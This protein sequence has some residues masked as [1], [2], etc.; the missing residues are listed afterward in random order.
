MDIYKQFLNSK[1]RGEKRLAILIDPDDTDLHNLEKL[2][3]I[4]IESNVDYFFVG[5][6]IIHNNQM[7]KVMQMLNMQDQVPLVIFPG[8]PDQV[9]TDADALL[10]LSLISGRNPDL[11]I[12]KHVESANQIKESQLEIIP[13]GYILIDGGIKTAVSYASNTQAIPRKEEKI[14]KATAIAGELL[15]LKTIYLEA[16]S[17]AKIPVPKSLIAEVRKSIDVPLMV[18][19]GI[20]SSDMASSILEAGADIIVVGNAVEKNPELI[21]DLSLTVHS[22][23]EV[24]K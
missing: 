14:A 12:S 3:Q 8:T 1:K 20:K 23:K 21:T 5:G 6:S 15:G 11:L 2:I 18:G 22:F 9:H 4:S 13:T 19:G 7:D 16:G 24:F 10:L 17:G